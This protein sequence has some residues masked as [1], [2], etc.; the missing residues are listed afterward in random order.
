MASP[1]RSRKNTDMERKKEMMIRRPFDELFDNFRQDI[2]DTVFGPL[3]QPLQDFRIPRMTE[4][5]ETR[6]P[7]CDILD[8]GDKYLISL[9]V[10]GIQ[11]DKIEIKATNEYI[12]ISGVEEAK[13]EKQEERYLLNERGYRSFFRRIHLEEDI[14]PTKVDATVEDG[15]LKIELPKQKPISTEETQIKIR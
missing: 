4:S 12:T 6:I 15:I 14:I 3:F 8:K 5:V 10:P 13:T 1:Q 11:K 2:E 9:E 7:L